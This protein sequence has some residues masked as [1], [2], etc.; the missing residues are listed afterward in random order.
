MRKNIARVIKAFREGYQDHGDSKWT[1]STDGQTIWSYKMRIAWREPDGSVKVVPVSDGPSVTT[2]SQIR[3]ILLALDH[4]PSV[5][6]A[7]TGRWPS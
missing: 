1:C 2:K 3:A 4:S 5:E 6:H 7:L